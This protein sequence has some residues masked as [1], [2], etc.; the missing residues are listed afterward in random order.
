[1]PQSR[2]H[3]RDG[4]ATA[5]NTSLGRRCHSPEPIAETAMPRPKT[6]RRD[7]D[8]TA[9]THRRDGDATEQGPFWQLGGGV[10]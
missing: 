10:G 5:Q 3:R 6:H 2:T 7:G 1:M 8:A 4:D 9:Q